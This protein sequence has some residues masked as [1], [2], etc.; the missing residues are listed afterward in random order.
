MRGMRRLVLE[1]CG[2]A[3]LA[4]LLIAC[5]G[6]T[7]WGRQQFAFRDAANYYYPLYLRVQ[8]EWQAGRVPL[9]EPEENGGMPLLGNPTAAVLYP[10]KLV[11]AALPFDA[12]MRV[13]VA[14]H[15]LGAAVAM[16]GLL[17]CWKIST[18][19][20]YL[21]AIAYA[22][23]APV[24]FQHCN[25]I[26]LVGAAWAPLGLL[27]AARWRE[28]RSLRGLIELCVALAMQA[29]G[30]DLQAGY[31]TGLCAVAYAL[32]PT[33]AGTSRRFVG[34]A[35]IVA[36][37]F[38]VGLTLFLAWR[39]P[40]WAESAA[41]ANAR[42]TGA[43]SPALMWWQ[44]PEA[45]RTLV[46]VALGVLAAFVGGIWIRR[47]RI[48]AWGVYVFGV[49]GSGCVAFALA[50]A[51][52]VPVFEFGQ[53]STRAVKGG[54][55]LAFWY[56]LWPGML[57]D[58]L[59]P[60]VF[61]TTAQ[62][63]AAWLRAVGPWNAELLWVPSIYA[64]AITVVMLL[65]SIGCRHVT[66]PE[67][68]MAG[69]ALVSLILSFG[70]FASPIW[71]ARESPVSHRFIG[72]HDHFNESG[73]RGDRYLADAAGS[74]YW[75][76]GQILPGFGLFRFP[77]KFVGTA[78]LAITALAAFGWD[79]AVAGETRRPLFVAAFLSGLSAVLWISVQLGESAIR[80]AWSSASFA[81]D[82]S[83]WG[84]F[85]AR[86]AHACL[87]QSLLHGTLLFGFIAVLIAIARRWPTVAGVSILLVTAVDLAQADAGLI[88]CVPESV[89]HEA[90]EALKRIREAETAQPS[91]GPYRVFHMPAWEPARWLESPSQHRLEELVA[92]GRAT[93][94]P[95]NG[96]PEGVSHAFSEGGAAEPAEI[97]A[98]FD[99]R[100]TP[101]PPWLQQ[102]FGF[103]AGE[104]F[105][106]YPR[107]SLDL[108]GARYFVLPMTAA[109]S[110]TRG[111]L[112]LLPH[113]ERLWPDEYLLGGADSAERQREWVRNEDWQL[114][115][116]PSA[117]PRAWIVHQARAERT[118]AMGGQETRD[119]I[120]YQADPFWRVANRHV[121]D[122]HE[123][124]W[125][126]D[127]A[128]PRARMFV[129]SIDAPSAAPS[130]PNERV[131]VKRYDPDRVELDAFLERPGVVILADTFYPGW[132]LTVDNAPTEVLRVNHAMRGALVSA[133]HHRLV[134]RYRPRSFVLGLALSVMGALV[135]GL[136]VLRVV[137]PDPRRSSGHEA[138]T[139]DSG[140]SPNPLGDSSTR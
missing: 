45:L 74:P 84:P 42:N 16:L 69:V 38:W 17:R 137:W 135:V 128:W 59:W 131:T 10:G 34:A 112:P 105:L 30:G 70:E 64:G 41:L 134:Y 77:A 4:G 60:N 139:Q 66:G 136:M 107:R 8:Q 98:F 39:A 46:I 102:R 54:G 92:W 94:A 12:A 37:A 127:T 19:G 14:A 11:F 85:D 49:L 99:P 88:R 47:R 120:L 44:R 51:Q 132:T 3:C 62:T 72:S 100:Y 121:Y 25:A 48:P 126:D 93:L 65:A 29:L 108:W 57:A 68:W 9:W 76:A 140:D 87:T 129:T 35:M 31:V 1:V 63:H 36:I 18:V 89:F 101:P 20:S 78:I 109:N 114:L 28:R 125:L 118:G 61:G 115:R 71:L 53:L 111:I 104:D 79:R 91:G 103:R 23:G 75:I 96:I 95:K 13:Y 15:V 80:T 110:T 24:L 32:V 26:Y 27:G 106:Y 138:P 67:R 73:D 2:L 33:Q 81:R 50:G 117:Y 22:F 7:F 133:G 6:Q 82:G 5:F 123:V 83:V 130:L 122:P 55:E 97:R 90:P 124:A 43:E 119:E 86:A 113:T 40:A 116:N 21:G 58:L 56:S 52:L